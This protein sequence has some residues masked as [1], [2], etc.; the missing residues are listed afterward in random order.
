[1]QA[2]PPDPQAPLIGR[3][4]ERAWVRQAVQRQD[5]PLI[6][7]AGPGGVGKTRLARALTTELAPRFPDGAY[8]VSLADL[9]DSAFVFP[10]I[11]DVIAPH[12]RNISPTPEGVRAA[13][14][15][16]RLLLTLDGLERVM[17]VLPELVQLLATCS[18]VV[19]LATN[20][21]PLGVRQE[22]DLPVRGL[23]VPDLAKRPPLA[24]LARNEAVRLL[25]QQVQATDPGFALT[26]AN[27]VEVAR[28]S[29]LLEGLPLALEL[30]GG[31]LS[32]LS[33]AA[34]LDQLG[35][36]LGASTRNDKR[37]PERQQTIRA[38][39]AWTDDLLSSVGRA[40]L[41][42]LS[43]FASG[44][45]AEAA[46]AT[47]SDAE[48]GAGAWA[49]SDAL[50]E[51]LNSGILRREAVTG[52]DRFMLPAMIREY[53]LDSLE[54]SD[55]LDAAQRRHATYFLDL[56]E[57][58]A[59][60]LIG[61]DQVAWIWRLDS[62]QVNLRMA[63]RWSLKHDPEM[64]LR[65]AASLWRYW[66]ARG[67]LRQGQH[68]LVRA[69]AASADERSVP[70]VRALNGLGVL[71]WAAGDLARALELQRARPLVGEST[72]GCLGDGGGRR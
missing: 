40:V 22:H 7:L 36:R 35:A 34:L 65:L 14:R 29:A 27:A 66:Y 52:E 21:S 63:L 10:A 4:Q 31:R 33:P 42:Q 6:T 16:A 71:V 28:I 46:Y 56:A 9:Q 32:A 39:I 45:D 20:R 15:S 58:A 18:G 11:A 68:W 57:D 51:L 26:K 69:L 61:P 62:E 72:R 8:F 64:A 12:Y 25:V 3:E 1:M 41:R 17:D 30:A 38:T 70:R 55:T 67:D 50:T 44:F 24:K 49:V 13:L 19:I 54:A 59:R 47:C 60:A 37:L 5:V 23:P 48:S 53:A 43:V 2:T